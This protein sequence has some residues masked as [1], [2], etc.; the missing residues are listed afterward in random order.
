LSQDFASDEYLVEDFQ[1]SVFKNEI[2]L[3]IVDKVQAYHCFEGVIEDGILY[4]QVR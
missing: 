3:R 4:I 2:C 1:K